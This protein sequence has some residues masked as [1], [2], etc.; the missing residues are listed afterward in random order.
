VAEGRHLPVADVRKIAD[1]RV[2][3]GS[4]A[5]KVKLVDRIGGMKETVRAAARAGGIKGEPKVVEYR[6]HRSIYDI[7][8]SETE[9]AASEAERAIGKQLID[10]LLDGRGSGSGL[11]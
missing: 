3:T 9:G 1:G 6:R 5:I 2:L 10:R 11:R 4:Q 7:L 8:G